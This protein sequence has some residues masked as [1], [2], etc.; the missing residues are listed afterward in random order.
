VF[1]LQKAL[2]QR[3]K[4]KAFQIALYFSENPKKYPLL[5]IVASLYNYFMKIWIVQRYHFQKDNELGKTIGVYSSYF[6]KEYRMA[7]RQYSGLQMRNIFL[8]LKEFDL[9][10][11]GVNNRNTQ[12]GQLVTELIYRILS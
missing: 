6:V 11:K 5:V 12:N 8:L 4:H 9:Y 7:A 2:G 3:N 10:S 1:E